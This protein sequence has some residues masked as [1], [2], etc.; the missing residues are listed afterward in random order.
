MATIVLGP[1][2][3][4]VEGTGP[5]T[6]MHPVAVGK[7]SPTEIAKLLPADQAAYM[8]LWKAQRD[9][10]LLEPSILDGVP[11]TSGTRV[12]SRVPLDSDPPSSGGSDDLVWPWV[13]AG[14]LVLLLLIKPTK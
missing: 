6:Y 14:I 2:G 4:M 11:T 5:L 9:A 8:R 12:N 1:A 13:V 7:L 3:Y 10:G